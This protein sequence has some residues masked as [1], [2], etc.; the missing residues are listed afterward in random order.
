MIAIKKHRRK[1]SNKLYSPLAP[2]LFF[3]LLLSLAILPITI[4]ILVNPLKTCVFSKVSAQLTLNG[5]PLANVPVIR[6]WEWHK[7]HEDRTTTNASGYF[8]FPAVFELSLTRFLPMELVI[9][10]GLYV[11]V[12]GEERQFW[13]NAKRHPEENSE[14]RGRQMILLCELSNKEKVYRDFGSILSTVCTW[15]T[16]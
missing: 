1:Y 16:P 6:R 2:R 9:G 4:M 12:D 15:R 10:Q 11:V 13:S 14:L 8:L 7:E 3:S 5:E